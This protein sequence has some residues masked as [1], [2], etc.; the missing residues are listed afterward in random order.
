MFESPLLVRKDVATK[1][2]RGTLLTQFRCMEENGIS[3]SV[4]KDNKSKE[5]NT[6]KRRKTNDNGD[7]GPDSNKRFNNRLFT[8]HQPIEAK[9][10]RGSV[11][12]K[13]SE[14]SRKFR[15]VY[16]GFLYGEDGKMIDKTIKNKGK[17]YPGLES[18]DEEDF[19][20]NDLLRIDQDLFQDNLTQDS[21]SDSD[22]GEETY[23]LAKLHQLN[24]RLREVGGKQNPVLR[25]LEIYSKGLEVLPRPISPLQVVQDN[26]VTMKLYDY[27]DLDDRIRS[28]LTKN[29]NTQDGRSTYSPKFDPSSGWTGVSTPTAATCKTGSSFPNTTTTL[30]N[31][32]P[33]KNTSASNRNKHRDITP[34]KSPTPPINMP[35]NSGLVRNVNLNQGDDEWYNFAIKHRSIGI[36]NSLV[37]LSLLRGDF[38]TAFRA[39]ALLIR[40][41]YVDVRIIWT[42]GLELLVWKRELRE[43]AEW[44]DLVE[45]W[46]E[47]QEDQKACMKS[48]KSSAKKESGSTSV[49]GSESDSE[50]SISDADSNSSSN[51]E[52]NDKFFNHAANKFN[53]KD[54]ADDSESENVYD[55]ESENGYEDA[56][57]KIRDS[58]DKIPS[59]MDAHTFAYD[60][61]ALLA[62]KITNIPETIGN[63]SKTEDE[64]FLEWLLV[65]FPYS[66]TRYGKG[67]KKVRAPQ[68]IPYLIMSK[69]RHSNPRQALDRLGEIMLES[70]YSEDPILYA[71]SG[72]AHIQL[73][74]LEMK[75]NAK[76]QNGMELDPK[77]KE[78]LMEKIKSFFE[79]CITRGGVI[80]QDFIN[81]EIDQLSGNKSDTDL[82]DSEPESEDDESKMRP[83]KEVEDEE[84]GE[85]EEREGTELD[86]E[87]ENGFG[88]IDDDKNQKN[89]SVEFE[90]F[91]F[92]ESED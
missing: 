50:N 77:R 18:S 53:T 73:Y 3:K 7:I 83:A 8:L 57:S 81:F 56:N 70:P 61:H 79:Q 64:D 35:R 23:R 5:N 9:P 91:S 24:R 29:T 36:V 38:K 42:I 19:D 67:R 30:P 15:G 31:H 28:I 16:S 86:Q 92:S 80:P 84:N 6:V 10:I 40:C 27:P 62:G 20:E 26:P 44:K 54:Q 33:V 71:L 76:S 75:E 37:H 85:E 82:N 45:A 12:S 22:F 90:G 41:Q 11:K 49:P 25:H 32:T 39:F 4:Q 17:P 59:N 74:L 21:D 78:F 60:S 63:S 88:E 68:I 2:E 66:R 43:K 47:E 1:G 34:T 55:N 13:T 89:P 87:M 58:V 46:K 51:L 48:G 14:V 72:I 52:D 65:N 69:L